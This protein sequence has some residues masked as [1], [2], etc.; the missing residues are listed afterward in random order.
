MNVAFITRGILGVKY[1]RGYYL[2]GR[3]VQVL[4]LGQNAKSVLVHYGTH[5][6]DLASLSVW[7]VIARNNFTIIV[8]QILYEL[9]LGAFIPCTLV[10]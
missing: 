6:I 7:E 1:I 2:K 3:L 10:R 8:S 5:L 9:F 4:F